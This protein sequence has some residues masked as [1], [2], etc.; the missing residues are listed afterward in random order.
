MF[1]D[2]IPPGGPTPNGIIFRMEKELD[3]AMLPG[4]KYISCWS[5]AGGGIGM[6]VDLDPYEDAAI[7][8]TLSKE[9]ADQLG[10]TLA[11]LGHVNLGDY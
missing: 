6:S 9:E 10:R 5:L 7:T 3:L 2:T 4:G 8:I 11:E 1:P